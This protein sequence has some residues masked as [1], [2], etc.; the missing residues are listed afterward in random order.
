MFLVNLFI[1]VV[2]YNFSLAQKNSKH[3]YLSDNQ[4]NWLQIQK[5]IVNA[6]PKLSN[7]NSEINFV[8]RVARKL[9]LSSY[10]QQFMN[11]VI[12]VTIIVLSIYVEGSQLKYKLWLENIEFFCLIMFTIE[13]ILKM[14]VYGF[15]K[16]FDD[17]NNKIDFI[18]LFNTYLYIF[19]NKFMGELF[20]NLF[21]RKNFLRLLVCLKLIWVLRIMRILRN[22]KDIQKLLKTLYISLPMTL[23]ILSLLLIIMFIYTIFGCKFFGSYFK[24]NNSLD[25]YINFSNFNYAI[26]TLFKISTADEWEMIMFYL[27]DYNKWAVLYFISFYILVS[28]IMINLFILILIEQFDEYY[29]NPNN[30]LHAFQD[31]LDDFE[32]VWSKF[33]NE[34]DQMKINQNKLVLFF[35]N[36]ISPIGLQFLNFKINLLRF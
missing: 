13:A 19:S 16:Y 1:G 20:L 22:F 33:C 25:E 23:N 34:T 17:Y 3:K 24:N 30:P 31:N 15:S 10:F 29:H 14:I 28:F 5:L 21:F 35:K 11:V 26:M 9:I 6:N 4:I 18:I 27:M 32:I 7:I 36:V 8:R 2:F 12:S